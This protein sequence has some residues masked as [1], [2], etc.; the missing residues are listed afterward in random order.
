MS[1]INE[2]KKYLSEND[3]KDKEILIKEIS[4]KF[5]TTEKSAEIYY[6]QWKKEFTGSNKCVPK[7]E[8]KVEAEL[9][10]APKEKVMILH[11][12]KPINADKEEVFKN[13]PKIKIIT[14]KLQGQCGE[15]MVTDGGIKIGDVLIKNEK[16]LEEYKREELKQFY[17]M[18]GEVS[19]ILD[20]IM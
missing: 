18:L 5:I 1:K 11:D 7:E 19:E 17:M 12:I 8:K 6:Y 16:E 4:K 3:G 20:M 13:K 14:A 9:K 15:Y 2:I 10:E